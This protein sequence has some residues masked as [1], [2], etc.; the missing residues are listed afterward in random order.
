MGYNWLKSNGDQAKEIAKRIKALITLYNK[1]GLSCPG[2]VIVTHSMGGIL[3][4][5]LM[6]KDYGGLTEKEVLGICHGVMPTHGAAATYKRMKAGFEGANSYH[7]VKAAEQTIT[8][9]VLGATAKEAQ[10]VIANAQGPLE[11]LPNVQYGATWLDVQDE[12]G[13]SL[14]CLPSPSGP[15]SDALSCI[16]NVDEQK[17]WRMINPKWI[18]PADKY[19]KKKKD[20]VKETRDR[21]ERA[22]TFHQKIHSIFHSTT[23][24]HYGNDPNRPSFGRVVWQVQNKRSPEPLLS[25]QSL[26]TLG[27]DICVIEDAYQQLQVVQKIMN[28]AGWKIITVKTAQAA[29]DPRTWKLIYENGMGQV[30][31]Q[32]Q[33]GTYLVLAIQAPKEPGDET[34]PAKASAAQVQGTVMEQ[35]G[36]EHQ[37]SY[38]DENAL[39]FTVYS[40]VK[41]ISK[42]LQNQKGQQ[43]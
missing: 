12:K 23:Y 36:Y 30:V 10:P 18:D 14:M 37:A 3:A 28:H 15:E 40:V 26:Y 24:A 38:K 19:I 22:L 11:L 41:I 6:H 34:V 27:P 1:G 39:Q 20:P 35:R 21:I 7:P 25:V 2:V 16:Y 29:G 5:A 33:T 42:H 9:Y 8:K 13:N 43:T 31:V 32:T 17:W 4:R